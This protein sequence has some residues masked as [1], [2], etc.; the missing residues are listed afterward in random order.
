VANRGDTTTAFPAK[1]RVKNAN[2]TWSSV[3]S[4]SDFGGT[5]GTHILAL[6]N[7][8]PTVTVGTITYPASQF[9]LKLTEQA[10]VAATY[11]NVDS[12]LWTS[13]YCGLLLLN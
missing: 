2:G 3:F 8:R 7:T 10:T 5:N 12:V 11:A 4:S 6:N 1:V 9:A 13:V